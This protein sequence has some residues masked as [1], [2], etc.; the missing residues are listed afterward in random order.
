[1]IEIR[2]AE[3]ADVESIRELFTET[4]GEH[5]FYPQYYEIAALTKLVFAD[6]TILLVAIDT[7]NGRV[8]GTASVV[9]SIAAYNDL[10]GEFGRPLIV[11]T[12]SSYGF[13]S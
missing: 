8:A 12:V 5:Y 3:L 4:Y 10:V 7:R 9:F 6:D 11:P 1:M 2:E 13:A